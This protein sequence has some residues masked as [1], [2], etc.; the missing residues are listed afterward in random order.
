MLSTYC[1]VVRRTLILGRERSLMIEEGCLCTVI[2][3]LVLMRFAEQ[4]NCPVS[5]VDGQDKLDKPFGAFILPMP[6][7]FSSIRSLPYGEASGPSLQS[8]SP[9]HTAQSKN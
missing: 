5:N 7:T 8:P 2:V 3:W 9:H 4:L 6:C 1:S